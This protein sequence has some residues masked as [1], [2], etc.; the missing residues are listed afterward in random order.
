MN[1][2]TVEIESKHQSDFKFLII[3]FFLH[4]DSYFF[5][6]NPINTVEYKRLLIS[7]LNILV[8]NILLVKILPQLVIIKVDDIIKMKH[9]I[10]VENYICIEPHGYNVIM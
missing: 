8:S 1:S 9:L 3:C 10:V 5:I 7:D 2:Y 6:C 4:K